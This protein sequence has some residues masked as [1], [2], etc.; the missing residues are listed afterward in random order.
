[1]RSLREWLLEQHLIG[2]MIDGDPGALRR[3][4]ALSRL[5]RMR[6]MREWRELI[7]VAD[8]H[9]FGDLARRAMV[10]EIV[11]EFEYYCRE[12]TS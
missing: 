4:K 5:Q 12:V 2:R 3:L 7:A 10:A 1:M 8:E 11:G 6:R 9:G